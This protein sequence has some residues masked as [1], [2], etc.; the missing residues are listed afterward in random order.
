MP[1]LAHVMGVIFAVDS[2]QICEFFTTVHVDSN[3]LHRWQDRQEEQRV[4]IEHIEKRLIGTNCII[5]AILA[6]WKLRLCRWIPCATFAYIC[7]LIWSA[8]T[9]DSSFR[10]SGAVCFLSGFHLRH[11]SISMCCSSAPSLAAK[12]EKCLPTN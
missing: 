7:P 1:M 9:Y 10:V 4:Y 12:Y 3:C 6:P 5:V 2:M 8:L 11:L